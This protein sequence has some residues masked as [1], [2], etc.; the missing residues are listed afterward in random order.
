LLRKWRETDSSPGP[1]TE[2]ESE[3]D[4]HL[5]LLISFHDPTEAQLV[6]GLLEANGIDVIV[7]SKGVSGLITG[8]ADSL[9]SSY[10]ILVDEGDVAD[11]KRVLEE[12]KRHYDEDA[13]WKEQLAAAKR[14]DWFLRRMVGLFIGA[15]FGV[16]SYLN[17]SDKTMAYV[18][19]SCSALFCLLIL[20][21]FSRDKRNGDRSY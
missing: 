12:Q 8:E 2:H 9:T 16:L 13:E 17:T 19:V 14:K 18:L 6:Q 7:D 10:D 4:P 21:S 1:N 11:A 3:P 15:T 5:V 20:F